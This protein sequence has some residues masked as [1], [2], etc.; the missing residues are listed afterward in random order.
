MIL[1]FPFALSG[2]TWRFVK[3]KD[4]VKLYICQQ[5]DNKLQ[6]FKGI[7]E[8]EFPAEKIYAKLEDINQTDWW[9]TDVTQFNVLIYE[10]DKQAQCYIV[11]R[12][13]WPFVNR[14][15]CVQITATI[16]R[17]T[18][19][20][21]LTA[22]PVSG[23]CEINNQCVRINDYREEWTIIPIDKNRSRVELEFYIDP[24]ISLPEW[25]VNMIVSDAPINV[26]NALKKY[27]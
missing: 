8:M 25:L 20:R 19:E 24:G 27:L 21:K 5:S 2:Q 9:T 18:G 6:S 13:P 3:E 16:N 15:L 22:V 17:L 7:A 1:L 11:Y 23:V 14:D 10:K 26:I 12:L 4:G